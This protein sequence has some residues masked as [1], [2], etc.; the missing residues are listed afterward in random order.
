MTDRRPRRHPLPLV[1]IPAC[2]KQ[3][4]ALP[5]H[6]AGDK[7]VRAVSDGADCLPLVIPALGDWHDVEDLVAR[8]DG[9]LITGSPSN[10]EPHH[11]AGPPS[12]AGTLH[13]PARD[14]LNLPLIR[15][16]VAAGVPVLAICRGLQEMNVA[17]GG[18][19]EQWLRER[20]DRDR[21]HA[22][23]D[24]PID[25]QYAPMHPVRLAPGGQLATLFGTDRITVNSVHF[26]GIDRLAPGLAIEAEAEDG[27]IEAV[28]VDG[29]PG[30]ALA[31]QWHP[32]WR[33]WEDTH[34]AALFRAF[35][36]A[37]RTYAAARGR[38][39]AAE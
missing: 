8:M 10:V 13:D 34:S 21:H 38:A 6:V 5:Y 14:D 18:S 36:D 1:G 17:F 23:A 25:E 33:F 31:V 30:F 24:R 19:L 22:G 29:A 26:Q 4:G 16:A 27:Q 3:V 12:R 9:F 39:K 28:A 11:Y 20:D 15:A 37:V 32:E 35:G 2:T 7:Y